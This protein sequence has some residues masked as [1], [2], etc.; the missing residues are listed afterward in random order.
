[1]LKAATALALAIGLMRLIFGELGS[2]PIIYN[3]GLELQSRIRAWI[4]AG[5]GAVWRA[6]VVMRSKDERRNPSRVKV[7][8]AVDPTLQ[9]IVPVEM[10]ED[11]A[12]PDTP[13]GGTGVAK[14]S[15]YRRFQTSARIVPPPP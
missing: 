11:F 4:D 7:E 13:V 14:Y 2:V 5:T 15:N 3:G 1:M 10:R 12:V 9:T 6:E 8:F